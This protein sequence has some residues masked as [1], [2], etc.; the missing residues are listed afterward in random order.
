LQYLHRSVGRG[1]GGCLK[2]DKSDA[3]NM[4]KHRVCVLKGKLIAEKEEIKS[5]KKRN[6]VPKSSHAGGS[7]RGSAL[8]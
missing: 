4:R 3:V 2:L 7:C 1:K 8:P 5:A 6:C